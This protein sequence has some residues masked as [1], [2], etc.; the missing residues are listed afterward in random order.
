MDKELMGASH[1]IVPPP[2]ESP[3]TTSALLLLL[4]VVTGLVDAPSYLQLGGVSVAN[5]TGN[6]VFVGALIGVLLVRAGV[7]AWSVLAAG[8]ILVAIAIITAWAAGSTPG[9]EHS[10]R[11]T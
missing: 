5:M 4:T 9:V 1:T 6:A 11:L 7:G 3:R 2:G 8:T 10:T